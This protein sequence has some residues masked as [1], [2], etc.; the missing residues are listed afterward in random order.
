MYMFVMNNKDYF[1]EDR[2]EAE[3]F[4]ISVGCS[5]SKEFISYDSTVAGIEENKMYFIPCL[6]CS[7]K[8]DDLQKQLN[9]LI[10]P[11]TKNCAK[12]V[13][14]CERPVS[15]TEELAFYF[16]Q[17]YNYINKETREI[18]QKKLEGK[19]AELD[20]A[21]LIKVFKR[22][23]I[24]YISDNSKEVGTSP[25]QYGYLRV[26]SFISSVENG[27]FQREPFDTD[28]FPVTLA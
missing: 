22:G 12:K 8:E 25:L 9:R 26:D 19:S 23:I 27:K 14:A 20:R 28:L 1:F 3:D 11:N 6:D 4:S 17:K 5:G 10:F 13:I 18:L 16:S 15:I 7:N 21:T 2:K 24:A